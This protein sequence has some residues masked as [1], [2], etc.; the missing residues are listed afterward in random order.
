VTLPLA[1][2][3]PG[4][5]QYGALQGAHQDAP[6]ADTVAQSDTQAASML[7][8]LKKGIESP[9]HEISR[10]ISVLPPIPPL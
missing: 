1:P 4:S 9:V 10:R 6:L 7:P 8:Q 3:L 2:L 5:T